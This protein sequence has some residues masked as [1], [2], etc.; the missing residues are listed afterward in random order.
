MTTSTISATSLGR[1]RCFSSTPRSLRLYAASTFM[2]SD[3]SVSPPL[4]TTRSPVP[5]RPE[6]G[7][8]PGGQLLLLLRIEMRR[9][10]DLLGVE[11]RE[12]PLDLAAAR[13]RQR[14]TDEPSVLGR[15]RSPDVAAALERGHHA[16]RGRAADA[17]RRGEVA[18]LH[19]APYPEHPQSDERG[20][21]QSVRGQDLGL[22][23]PP[24]RGRGPEEVGY[25]RHRAE[26]QREMA[27]LL[28][29]LAFGGQKILV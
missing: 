14:H 26:V 5:D 13:R 4:A 23:V 27:E 16:G 20:P 28:D 11:P 12:Q 19:L 22:H 29:D 7:A 3:I 2:S 10:R 25:R 18:R 15:L 8:Q 17:D 6:H 9:D 21:R 24:D 1:L